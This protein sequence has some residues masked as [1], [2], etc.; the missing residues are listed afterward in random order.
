MAREA[1][2]GSQTRRLPLPSIT[3]RWTRPAPVKP[4]VRRRFSPLP[5]TTG[6][7]TLIIERISVSSSDSGL[8]DGPRANTRFPP[9]F[10]TYRVSCCVVS[11][12]KIFSNARPNRMT[13][14]CCHSSSV[15]GTRA[16]VPSSARLTIVSR[17]LVDMSFR[18][19]TLAGDSTYLAAN[20]P[21]RRPIYR[22]GNW[23]FGNEELIEMRAPCCTCDAAHHGYIQDQIQN[24]RMVA[25]RQRRR[26]R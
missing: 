9:P 5:H 8:S 24:Y 2:Q 13:S 14:Y 26:P 1:V 12:V 21:R 11:T 23:V 19:S 22:P 3:V 17:F 25:Q 15:S 4:M 16:A 6:S 10:D 18:S 7:R 20:P